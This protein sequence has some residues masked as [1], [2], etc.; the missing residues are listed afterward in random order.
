MWLATVRTVLRTGHLIEASSSSPDP[1][2]GELR[3]DESGMLPADWPWE[4]EFATAMICIAA[5]PA[6]S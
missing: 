1:G 2:V 3:R 6:P 4:P 5:I